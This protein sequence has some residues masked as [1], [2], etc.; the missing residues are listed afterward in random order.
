MKRLPYVILLLLLLAGAFL[1][2]AWYNQRGANGNHIGQG[3]RRVLY[4]VDPMNPGH[5]SDKPGVAPCGMPMEP[6]YAD[7]ESSAEGSPITASMS[8]GTVRITP[9]K[10][11]LIGVRVE[12]VEMAPHSHALRTLGRVSADE[13]RTHSITAGAEGWVW[14]VRGGTTGSLVRKEELMASVYNYQFLTRQQQY[15]YALEFGERRQRAAEGLPGAR[16]PV[17]QPQVEA[18]IGSHSSGEHQHG[19]RAAGEPQPRPYQARSQSAAVPPAEATMVP[20]TPGGPTGMMNPTGGAVYTVRDQLEVAKLELYSLGVGDYQLREIARNRRV[21]TDLE[22]RSP[23]TGIVLARNVSPQQRFDRG[24]ELFRVADLTRVWILA[25]V[26]EREAQHI[27]PGMSARVSL[28]HHG[29]VFEAQVTDVPPPYDPATRALRVRLEADNPELELRPAMF[30]DVEFLISF[31]PAIIVPSDA[32]LDSGLRKTVFVDLGNGFFEPRTVQTGWRFGDRVEIL[33]GLTPGE[34]IVVS[35]NFLI[36]S[37]SRMKLAAA[38]LY[39]TPEKDPMNGMD[40]YPS[41]AKREGLTLEFEGKTYYFHSEETKIAFEKAHGLQEGNSTET[42]QAATQ[43]Q[44]APQGL[45]IDPVCRMPLPDATTRKGNHKIEH[46]GKTY[47]FC[48][49]WCKNQFAKQP[50]RYV[51]NAPGGEPAQTAPSHAG[52]KHD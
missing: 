23:V 18:Q 43:D 31:P 11:Q 52:H 20:T 49:D 22:I 47:Y 35:G 13:N 27:R 16:Q 34:K 24:T 2:G 12:K 40:V 36:D 26:F 21:A 7:D 29:K 9:Q 14:E 41:E 28:P 44:Q 3:G 50:E 25:D 37:E 46:L 15:L 19:E 51:K 30:V 42:G 10:Q 39:G 45:I 8:P 4:Y 6:V 17:A 5:T 32:I 33:G 48:S 38:G 1:G